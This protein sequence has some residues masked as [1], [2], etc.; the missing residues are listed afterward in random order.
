MQPASSSASGEL[1][2]VIASI[3][4][5]ES[6]VWLTWYTTV[7][8]FFVCVDLVLFKWSGLEVTLDITSRRAI[9]MRG[10]HSLRL[11]TTG[12]FRV[13]ALVIRFYLLL[14]IIISYVTIFLQRFIIGIPAA[15]A[16]NKKRRAFSNSRIFLRAQ[17]W[18]E[19]SGVG[20]DHIYVRH[21]KYRTLWAGLLILITPSDIVTRHRYLFSHTSSF[22]FNRR[23]RTMVDGR[24]LQ[25]F[26]FKTRQPIT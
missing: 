13:T 7:N 22:I 16:T 9:A 17:P 3:K 8:K 10:M 20:H 2:R 15:V 24:A 25:C 26:L 18:R 19:T 6:D 21:L 1:S 5:Y 11:Q 4:I 23:P 14:F 12:V